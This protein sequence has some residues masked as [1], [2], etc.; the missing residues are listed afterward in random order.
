MRFEAATPG[1]AF[2]CVMYDGYGNR[3]FLEI[4]KKTQQKRKKKKKK[5]LPRLWQKPLRG[6]RDQYSGGVG[7]PTTTQEAKTCHKCLLGHHDVF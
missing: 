1:T 5:N 4:A 2:H 7:Y 6:A 3:S